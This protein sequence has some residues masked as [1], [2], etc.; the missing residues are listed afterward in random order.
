MFDR[1]LIVEDSLKNTGSAD[2]PDGFQFEARLGYYRGLGLSMIEDLGVT[3]DGVQMPRESI[4]FEIDG[5][6]FSLDEMET[7]YD[8]RWPF[9]HKAVIRV[10]KPGGLSRG[11]HKLELTER[12]R[13]SY[14]PFPSVSSD[15]KTLALSP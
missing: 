3:V 10:A 4:R 14:M 13:V 11:A 8:R 2:A 5:Q 9:G 7:Q 15:A 12:L 1:Y 6:S